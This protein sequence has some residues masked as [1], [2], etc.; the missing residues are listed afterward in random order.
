[1]NNQMP[2]GFMPPFNQNNDIRVLNQRVENLERSIR[3]LERRV[4]NLESFH[5]APP[6]PRQFD[7]NSTNF[8]TEEF[9][10]NYMI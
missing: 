10:N 1:M 8:N 2:F 6:R 9:P 5:S 4:S 3:R 7:N